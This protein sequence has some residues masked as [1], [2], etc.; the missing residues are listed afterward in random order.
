M[1]KGLFGSPGFWGVVWLGCVVIQILAWNKIDLPL[2]LVAVTFLGAV[3]PPA[4]LF[5]GGVP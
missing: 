3:A 4:R 1:G 5:L 2:W